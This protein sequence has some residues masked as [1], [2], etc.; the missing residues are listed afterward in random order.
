MVA[1]LQQTNTSA[2]NSEAFSGQPVITRKLSLAE[3]RACDSREGCLAQQM[4]EN[5][6]QADAIRSSCRVIKAGEHLFRQGEENSAIY[7]IKSG[8]VKS[9]VTTEDG[10]EQVLGFPLTGDVLGIDSSSRGGHQS[11]AVALETISICKLPQDLLSD[12]GRGRVYPAL[13]AD[14][15]ALNQHLVLMLTRKDADGRVASFLCGLSASFKRNGY[16]DIAFNL[17]MSRQDIGNYLGLAIE[18]VSR[19]L[20]RFQEAGLLKA[21]RRKIEILDLAALQLLAHDKLCH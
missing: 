16:S 10:E 18:T 6:T 13:L 12:Q 4:I 21:D 19:C 5:P 7:V 9:F 17:T 1:L 8:S 14:Q 3:C 20:T 15:A 2:S 11:S